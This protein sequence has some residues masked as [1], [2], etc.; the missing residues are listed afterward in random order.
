MENNLDRGQGKGGEEGMIRQG[1][2]RL[3]VGIAGWGWEGV[4]KEWLGAGRR[5]YEYVEELLCVC[6]CQN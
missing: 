4:G 5:Q 2:D 6:A 3:G 1:D